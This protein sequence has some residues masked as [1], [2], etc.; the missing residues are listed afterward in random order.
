MC[1]CICTPTPSRAFHRQ[2]N[3]LTFRFSQTLRTSISLIRS[4]LPIWEVSSSEGA[5]PRGKG[6]VRPDFS[7]TYLNL[8]ITSS[9]LCTSTVIVEQLRGSLDRPGPLRFL[10][11]PGAL[12]EWPNSLQDFQDGD[13]TAIMDPN[14]RCIPW[15]TRPETLFTSSVNWQPIPSPNCLF[16][17]HDVSLLN[18]HFNKTQ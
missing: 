10:S 3:E 11:K 1:I 13:H 6:P 15:L 7:I 16:Q 18:I 14:I 5:G 4:F 2:R 17:I 9:V 12:A 8:Q